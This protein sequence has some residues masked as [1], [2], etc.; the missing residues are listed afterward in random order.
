MCKSYDI[1]EYLELH[2]GHPYPVS[3]LEGRSSSSASSPPPLSAGQAA[4]SLPRDSG[5]LATRLL[6]PGAIDR[7]GFVRGRRRLSTGSSCGTS[8]AGRPQAVDLVELVHAVS[9]RFGSRRGDIIANQLSL[10]LPY[11]ECCPWHTW[12]VGRA[13]VSSSLCGDTDAGVAC[14]Q[15]QNGGMAGYAGS[16]YRP[17]PRSVRLKWLLCILLNSG[18]GNLE[19]HCS[20]CA[21][22]CAHQ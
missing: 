14:V 7:R 17:G 18:L 13:C 20:P 22:R 4:A 16:S 12:L 5:G 6:S 11:F 2:R 19:V 3:I 8:P 1:Y 15:R 21:D 9:P 10:P